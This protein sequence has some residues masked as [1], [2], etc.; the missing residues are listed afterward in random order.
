MFNKEKSKEF[1]EYMYKYKI[2]INNH[3]YGKGKHIFV[4]NENNKLI[5]SYTTVKS[6]VNDL[7]ISVIIIIKYLDSGK[8]YKNIFFYSKRQSDEII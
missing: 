8:E 6:V 1:I 7:Y 3:I 4:Y 5:K 2:S